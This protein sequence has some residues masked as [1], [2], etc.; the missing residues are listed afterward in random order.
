[1]AQVTESRQWRAIAAM[2]TKLLG[3][4]LMPAERIRWPISMLGDA[5]LVIVADSGLCNE[6]PGQCLPRNTWEKTYWGA[7]GHSNN[8]NVLP[9]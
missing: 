6:L 9:K 2:I 7:G 1:M 5:R 3:R 8:P 4:W